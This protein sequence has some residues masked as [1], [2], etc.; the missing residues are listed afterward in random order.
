MKEASYR[1]FCKK[2]VKD[3]EKQ[4]K[5]FKE[6]LRIDSDGNNNDYRASDTIIGLKTE[7]LNRLTEDVAKEV[8]TICLSSDE[9]IVSYRILIRLP[10]LDSITSHKVIGLRAC[11]YRGLKI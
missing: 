1:A 2:F 10:K 4:V 9:E 6:F 3:I 11:T 7:Y 8:E 5:H